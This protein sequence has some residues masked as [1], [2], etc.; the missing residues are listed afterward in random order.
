MM[1]KTR[2]SKNKGRTRA[3]SSQSLRVDAEAVNILRTV[4]DHEAF[5]FYEAV[6]KPAGEV[7]R[8]LFD[9]LDAVRAVKSESVMFHLG[10]GDFQ[11][12]IG[13]VLG[14]SKLVA[15]LGEISAS[16]S[17]DIRMSICRTVENRIKE[18]RESSVAKLA[19]ERSTVL[20]PSPFLLVR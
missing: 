8:N 7:A 1:K 6:G 13:T 14:D 10:R 17:N 3:R 18:L 4:G 12:W 20:L 2:S 11:N 5:Y 19:E 16:N 9:F 15:K